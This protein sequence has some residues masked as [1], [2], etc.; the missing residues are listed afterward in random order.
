MGDLP[1]TAAING[2]P[3]NTRK[4]KSYDNIIFDRRA[5]AEYTGQ[6]GVLDLAAEFGL[7]REQALVVS[8]HMPVWAAF[9]AVEN[10][11]THT[12]GGAET[13]RRPTEPVRR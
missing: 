12:P 13:A 4:T 6:W 8:D 11:A 2:V 1:V 5:T 10:G 9:G 3:T 7:T